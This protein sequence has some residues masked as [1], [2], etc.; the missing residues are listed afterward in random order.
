MET[1]DWPFVTSG[2]PTQRANNA[3]IWSFLDYVINLNKLSNKQLN[4]Q[5]IEI[6]WPPSDITINTIMNIE[7]D[8]FH[9]RKLL[10]KQANGQ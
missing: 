1:H 2:F 7:T 8:L 10:N 3:L 6:P 9:P 4:G 5:W